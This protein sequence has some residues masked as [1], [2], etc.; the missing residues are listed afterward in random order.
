MSA[1]GGGLPLRLSVRVPGRSRS[2]YRVYHP[3]GSIAR[4]DAAAVF[5][6]GGGVALYL[7]Y[8]CYSIIHPSSCFC[9]TRHIVKRERGFSSA[10]KYSSKQSRFDDSLSASADLFNRSLPQSASTL[11]R[12][13]IRAPLCPSKVCCYYS[14]VGPNVSA[15]VAAVG[16]ITS[17]R[18]R[19]LPLNIQRRRYLVSSYL[20]RYLSASSWLRRVLG[21]MNRSIMTASGITRD[22]VITVCYN[23]NSSYMKIIHRIRV[24]Y[25]MVR[26]K[27]IVHSLISATY[28]T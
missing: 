22:T 14:R 28:R 26:P 10:F 23:V 2:P 24:P 17:Y 6:A 5:V 19:I 21:L 20:P 8:L 25:M 15:A 13:V 1:V 9:V 12:S 18:P 27:V 7:S 11:P 16:D 3:C 4:P